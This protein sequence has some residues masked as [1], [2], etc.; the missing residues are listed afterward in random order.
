MQGYDA[1]I[2]TVAKVGAGILAASGAFAYIAP[3]ENFKSYGMDEKQLDSKALAVMR[4]V[5]MFQIAL[6]ALLVCDPSD[7]NSIS[8]LAA[9]ATIFVG[10]PMNETLGAPKAPA[11]AWMCLTG[12]LGY[13]SFGGLISPWVA[14]ALWGGNGAQFH[15]A[16]K[17]TERRNDTCPRSNARPARRIL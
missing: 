12:L 9:A 10:M 5:G 3:A 8:H 4:Q 6:G 17:S 16:P 1:Y 13:F 14:V 2:S 11:L 15:F 7:V